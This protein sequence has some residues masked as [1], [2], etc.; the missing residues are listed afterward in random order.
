MKLD[1]IKFKK[2]IELFDFNSM[3]GFQ[4]LEEEVYNKDTKNEFF[5]YQLKN[6]INKIL[7]ITYYPCGSDLTSNE[8]DITIIYPNGGSIN[9]S[10]Y[11]AYQKLKQ[12]LK[13]EDVLPYR[14]KVDCYNVEESIQFQLQKISGLL[15]GEFKKYLI[16]E[17]CMFIPIHEPRD[18]Y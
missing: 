4:F 12:R 10:S 11:Q 14:F 9:L 13:H 17:D 8:I 15:H 16:T 1:T 3:L 7:S 5:Q 6:S 2:Q 18:D